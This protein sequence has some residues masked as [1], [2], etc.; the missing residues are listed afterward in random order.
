MAYLISGLTNFGREFM[1]MTIINDNC[2]QH[3]NE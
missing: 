1:T 2:M 3:F